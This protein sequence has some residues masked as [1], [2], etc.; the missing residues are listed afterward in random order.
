[1][2][3]H[4]GVTKETHFEVSHLEMGTY[5]S[6]VAAISKDGLPG[7]MSQ[8][9]RFTLQHD[10]GAPYL[11]IASPQKDNFVRQTPIAVRGTTEPDATLTL[12]GDAVE[13]GPEGRF[14]REVDLN[15]GLNQLVF[16]VTDAAGHVT[17][18]VR[19]V[20]YLPDQ[21]VVIHYD[22]SLP[23]LGEK[24]FVTQDK[25]L[26]LSRMTT[27]K[28]EIQVQSDT[29]RVRA[30]T[31][32]DERG[33]F[34]LNT[35]VDADRATLTLLAIAPSGFVTKD[36]LQVTQDSRSANDYRRRVATYGDFGCRYCG[37]KATY[38]APRQ[39]HLTTRS[40]P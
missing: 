3:N 2:V 14:E 23:R 34:N 28:W 8:V 39:S 30:S 33:R 32:A 4:W 18:R 15:T 12:L 7:K 25:A 9:R 6:R 20:I 11:S 37:Y 19:S 36:T 38:V 29:T 35:P 10:N 40:S 27:P 1:M 22:A 31:F 5:Y 17:R 13:V 16:E 21:E 26:S 24:H